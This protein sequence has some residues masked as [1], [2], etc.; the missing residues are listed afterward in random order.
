MTEIQP[1][2]DNYDGDQDELADRQSLTRVI[3]LRT[4]LEDISEDGTEMNWEVT[5][6]FDYGTLEP[7]RPLRVVLTIYGTIPS[8]GISFTDPGGTSRLFAVTMS[9]LDGSLELMEIR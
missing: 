1:M 9:G 2:V 8:Y 6:L 3:G 5:Q 7:E 4:E